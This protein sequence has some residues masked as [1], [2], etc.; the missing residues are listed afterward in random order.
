MIAPRI[1][2]VRSGQILSTDLVNSLIG[3]TEYA[4]DLLRQYKLIAGDEMYVEPHFDGTRVSY[5]QPVAGGATPTLPLLTESEQK[6]ED[7]LNGRV[8]MSEITGYLFDAADIQNLYG[9][10]ARLWI[11]YSVGGTIIG[12][13]QFSAFP[14]PGNSAIVFIVLGSAQPFPPINQSMIPAPPYNQQGLTTIVQFFEVSF[15]SSTSLE[16]KIGVEGVNPFL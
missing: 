1:P 12:A 4:A 13:P 3:R 2:L 16:F 9:E 10:N 6:L 7:L 15:G 5:L 14:V 8:P 11:Q